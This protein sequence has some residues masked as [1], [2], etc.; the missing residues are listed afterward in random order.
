MLKTTYSGSRLQNVD[1]G[2]IEVVHS[3]KPIG[4]EGNDVHSSRDE[5]VSIGLAAARRTVRSA[6]ARSDQSGS[7]LSGK[8]ADN[9]SRVR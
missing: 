2:C 1:P 5:G 9:M 7:E 3:W 4:C 8:R 6:A